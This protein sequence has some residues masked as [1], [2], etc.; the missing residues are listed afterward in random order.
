MVQPL[1][2]TLN[3]AILRVVELLLPGGFTVSD[4]APATYDKLTSH[5]DAGRKMVVWSGASNE[6]IYGDPHV[7]YAFRAWH[8]WCHWTGSHPFT[9]EGE[10]AVYLMQCGHLVSLFGPSM[11]LERWCRIL[12]AEIVGQQ[13]YFY[14]NGC[15]PA[16]QR[17]FI[18]NYLDNPESVIQIPPRVGVL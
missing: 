3:E 6:T 7:N 2:A 1:D 18:E 14:Q 9:P 4:F 15:Y 17:R 8:D 16:N 5:L 12:R 13:E 11:R 10:Y